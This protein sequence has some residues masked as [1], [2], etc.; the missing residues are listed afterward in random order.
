MKPQLR[1]ITSCRARAGQHARPSHKHCK[2]CAKHV[3]ASVL[4]D[5]CL[6][7][8]R[9]VVW[10]LSIC[11]CVLELHSLLPELKKM[12]NE[13]SETKNRQNRAKTH[14]KQKLKSPAAPA[15]APAPNS[16]S[17]QTSNNK[18][19]SKNLT[20]AYCYLPGNDQTTKPTTM[21]NQNHRNQNI[22]LTCS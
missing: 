18:Q 5:A 14:K 12:R 16:N 3:Y 9:D 8:F 13:K 2:P 17:K 6:F 20:C 15:P 10:K 7:T 11:R 21:K 22:Q 4:K 1:Q 19:A